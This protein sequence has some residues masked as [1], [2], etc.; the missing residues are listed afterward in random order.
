MA[1]IGI[2][3]PSYPDR[4]SS[5]VHGAA[6]ELNAEQRQRLAL[7]VL[8]G[9]EPVMEL[10]QRHGVSRKFAYQQATKGAQALAQAFAPSAQDAEVL[11]Y[12]PVTKAWLRQVVLGLVLLCHSSFR[13]V[14]AF[15]RDLLDCPLSLGSVHHI[16]HQAVSIARQIN[17][18]QDLSR[19]RASS[20]DELFQAGQPVLAGIDLD[21][22]YCY[23][24]APEAHRDAETW[25]I[26]LL[27]LTE[28]GL[29]PDYT[30]A[31]GGRGLRAGQALAWPGVPCHGDVFHGLR[32]LTRLSA[33]LEQRAYAAIAQRDA[34]EQRMQ[35][36]KQHRQGRCLSQRLARARIQEA[37]AL[38]L[39]DEVHTLTHWMQH[40]IL[41][42]AGPDAP[43]RQVLYDFVME[44]L[45]ALE[46]LDAPRL[47]PVRQR[48]VN[49]RDT[50]LAFATRL[51]QALN[52]IA[53]RF[54]VPVFR[55][56]QVLALQEQAPTT[57]A[58]WSQRAA[59][60]HLLHGQLYA[61]DQALLQL[62]HRLHRASSLV[63]NLNSRLRNYFFLRR[64]IG[65]QYL[66]LLRFFLN[67]SPF[68]R[69]QHPERVG[70]TPAALLSAQVH[71]HWL[72]LLG[73][74]RF[75]RSPQAA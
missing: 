29:H 12:L 26:H 23:L 4:S 1:T 15:F 5:A 2:D 9:R 48:L 51:D 27:D 11:F 62:R 28:Q 24:L 43:T 32:E 13:G 19:V 47:R 17:A 38:R 42:L 75:Q 71:P 65:P 54:A 64:Q 53:Q 18:D 72:E 21:S 10:A 16:V 25:G 20:H 49:Q 58:Y 44:R 37:S 34:L 7:Q 14:I 45:Q 68:P 36:A 50:L 69:S 31:D 46:A 22:T 60:Q 74:T 39:A 30:V 8:A 35:K 6:Q 73:F 67:H 66:E 55:L 63:E 70:K 56:R 33:T 57:P 59:L 61:I 41:A 52:R 40:D 3:T